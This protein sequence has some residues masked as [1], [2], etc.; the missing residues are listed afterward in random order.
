[1]KIIFVTQHLTDGGA[2]R[3][4]IAFANALARMGEDVCI[5]YLENIGIDYTLDPKVQTFFLRQDSKVHIPKLRGLCNILLPVQQLHKIS[6]DVLISDNLSLNY[7]WK[8]RVASSF[9]NARMVYAVVNNMEKKFSNEKRKKQ[10]RRVCRSVDAI[11]IQTEGQRKFIP[12]YAQKKVF[13]VKNILDSQFL[14]TQKT[15]GKEIRHFVSAG[16]LHPQKNQKLLV[17]AFAQMIK[18]TENET[19][20]LTIY[21]K[22][23]IKD[24]DTEEKLRALIR[25]YHLEDRVFLPGWVKDMEDKFAQ[26]DAFVFGSD[27]EGLPYALMEAMGSGLPCISTDCPTGPSD[28]I[29]N[30]ENGILVPVGD[31]D[32]MSCAMKQLIEQPEWAEKMGRQARKT[33]QEWGNSEELANRLL[34]QLRRICR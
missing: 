30:G 1:M 22:N 6:G 20:T 24:S 33:M 16:R 31:V 10:Y 28:L 2:E 25:D 5:A 34:E 18:L 13:H 11:W 7:N 15:Y 19:A 29:Q 26:A 14:G 12:S 17:E 32:A 21:G 4:M 23:K 27:Y 3:G 9:S 8:V